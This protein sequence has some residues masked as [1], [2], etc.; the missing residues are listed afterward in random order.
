MESVLSGRD[1]PES[2][3]LL[4]AK[5][6]AIWSF[7]VRTVLQGE[8]VWHVVDPITAPISES[9]SS[10]QSGSGSDIG[11]LTTPDGGT[12][13][14]KQPTS[15]PSTPVSTLNLEDTK[16]KAMRVI[17]PTVHDSIAP[18]IMH[19]SDPRLVWIKLRDL[20]KSKSMNRQLSIKSQLYS[21]RMSE[22]MSI[23]D[24]LRTVSDLT[25]QLANI[26]VI[27]PDEELVDRVL[28]S[29]PSSWDVLRQLAT[30]RERP[31]TFAELE[32]MLLHEDSIRSR[33][34]DRKE[35][36]EALV[37]E[38]EAL[39]SR[40]NSR[41]N[42]QLPSQS[43]TRR[44]AFRGHDNNTSYGA[45][46]GTSHPERYGVSGHRNMTGGRF[47]SGCS[48]FNPRSGDVTNQGAC[49]ECGSP[50]HW[51]DRCELR[52]LKNKVRELEMDSNPTSWRKRNYI[53]TADA[54]IPDQ[55]L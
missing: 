40:F 25:G 39:Y 14:E 50:Y 2:S 27:V 54:S 42:R 3:K 33:N 13:K 44:S 29:L 10:S 6:Y 28:T 22:K 21:L 45:S 43:F 1:I 20:Y 49:N 36:E 18:H 7:K 35:R 19:I 17:V 26:G 53:N 55:S 38:Q 34:R 30:Q 12:S 52:M 31:I 48:N 11:T 51:A 47:G 9:A 15:P 41:D 5:N 37:L 32:A 46:R 16:Y 4:G 23:E 8:R 24:L